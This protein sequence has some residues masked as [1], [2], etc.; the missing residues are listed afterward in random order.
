MMYITVDKLR[1]ID[2]FKLIIKIRFHLL[3]VRT[4]CTFFFAAFCYCDRV[5]KNSKS[6]TYSIM[7]LYKSANI[8][9]IP[10]SVYDEMSVH[11]D[12]V[13]LYIRTILN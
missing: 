12:D 10:T 7:N 3:R 5:E 1:V 4:G 8:Y 2:S 6:I 11:T 9:S 13:E